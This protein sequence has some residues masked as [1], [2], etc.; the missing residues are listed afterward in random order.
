M[1]K[2]KMRIK[3][4]VL[5]F[6]IFLIA[7]SFQ[8][9]CSSD[10][11]TAEVIVN[12]DFQEMWEGN[13]N[14]RRFQEPSSQGSTAVESALELSEKYAILSTETNMLR[15]NNQSLTLEN[16]QLKEQLVTIQKQL[17]QAQNEL[18]EA[19]EIMISMRT[20]L[21]NWKKDVLGFRN[22]MRNAEKAQLEALLKIMKVLGGDVNIEVVQNDNSN[23][24]MASAK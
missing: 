22:E 9:G 6:V 18:N 13:S 24:T 11:D 5:L 10:G 16:Q 23:S 19:N 7:L 8:H 17:R 1:E 14:A 20:E 21:N 3:K 4:K 15:Q 12:P 2:N